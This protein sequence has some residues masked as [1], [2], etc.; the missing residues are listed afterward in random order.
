MLTNST[1]AGN[2]PYGIYL[3]G[4]LLDP[5]TLTL[6]NSIVRDNIF[7]QVHLGP[8]VFATVSYSNVEGGWA[9]AGNIDADPLFFDPMNGDYRLQPGSPCIDAGDNTL[10]PTRG[11]F[12]DLLGLPRFV[13]DPMTPD[14]GIGD[15]LPLFHITS[16]LPR[17]RPVVDMGAYEFQ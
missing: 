2:C 12:V 5:A 9:G 8:H 1:I 6:S 11:N 10:F 13:D 3:A 16:H 14:T 17:A 4:S 15:F 7:D